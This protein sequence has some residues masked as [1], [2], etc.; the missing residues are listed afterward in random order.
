MSCS[1]RCATRST[2]SI[3]FVANLLS[4]SRIEAG[5]FA[6]ERQAVDVTE[7]VDERVRSLAPLL[8]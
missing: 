8:R 3:G 6:P 4:L 2:A 7:L 1:P 5:A